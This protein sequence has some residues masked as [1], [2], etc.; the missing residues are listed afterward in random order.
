MCDKKSSHFRLPEIENEDE[1]WNFIATF[2]EYL[3]CCEN[4]FSSKPLTGQCPRCQ[5]SPVPV[6]KSKLDSPRLF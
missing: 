2:L 1:F 6:K 4:L 3:E 5:N